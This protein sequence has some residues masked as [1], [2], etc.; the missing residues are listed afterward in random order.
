ML[1]KYTA[2]NKKG[3]I[4]EGN[5]E[6][7]NQ[8]VAI[9]ALQRR[10]LMVSEISSLEE[11]WFSSQAGV[12]FFNKISSKDIVML[13]R[14]L[15]NLFES[16]VSALRI[17]SLLAEE[18]ENEQLR[19]ILRQMSEDVKGGMQI[20]EAMSK[21][22]NAF[23]S[24]YVNMVRAGE[25]SGRLN[26]TFT[27]LADYLER[28]YELVSK[29]KHA[30]MYPAVVIAVFFA[31]MIGMFTFIIPE[32]TSIIVESG[33]EIPI[34]TRAVMA[35]SDGMIRYG[36]LVAAAVVVVLILFLRWTRS[37]SGKK[38][39]DNFKL[40]MPM[41][42]DLFRKLYLSRLA[43]NMSTMI[44]S[45]ISM[46]NALEITADVVGNVVFRDIL[47]EC[48]ESIRGGQTL[49]DAF[50]SYDEIPGVMTQMTLVGEESGSLGE[51]LSTLSRFYRREFSSSVDTALGLIEPVMIVLLGLGVGTLLIS[52][53][54]PIYDMTTAAL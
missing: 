13:S 42:G 17:F 15:A 34:Y 9:S 54:M 6:A 18:L 10:G 52:V 50:D 31:V 14:Q 51:I 39:W 20:S 43:D 33:Q 49:S 47:L 46:V 12:P 30:L 11:G 1:F 40:N 24:F 37:E 45:G 36:V 5:I 53:L 32:I 2:V 16:Q 4:Q 22:P 21:H 27:Y 35:I 19:L 3:E 25:E 7:V 41:L 29:A 8:E 38:K 28:N 26:Q 23:S 48:S 44:S